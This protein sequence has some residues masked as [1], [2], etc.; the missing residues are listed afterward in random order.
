MLDLR[1]GDCLPPYSLQGLGEFRPS[2]DRAALEVL[3][4]IAQRLDECRKRFEPC[5]C[6]LMD[7]PCRCMSVVERVGILERHERGCGDDERTGARQ[8]KP[9]LER[10]AS[11]DRQATGRLVA[12]LRNSQPYLK[13][14][15]LL[16]FTLAVVVEEDWRIRQILEG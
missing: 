2:S 14:M 1:E 5:V 7:K 11:K 6:Y 16:V 12:K 10:E 8:G 9:E 3:G 13:S 15:L 4:T